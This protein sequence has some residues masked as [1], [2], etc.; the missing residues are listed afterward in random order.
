MISYELAW[1]YLISYSKYNHMRT[2]VS[3]PSTYSTR[4]H[5]KTSLLSARLRLPVFPAHSMRLVEFPRKCRFIRVSSS[6][7]KAI[8]ETTSLG[9]IVMR[10]SWEDAHIQAVGA[11]DIGW[12]WVTQVQQWSNSPSPTRKT[13]RGWFLRIAKRIPFGFWTWL[14]TC[15]DFEEPMTGGSAILGYQVEMV[16]D[17]ADWAPRI[18]AS[19]L[20][21][22]SASLELVRKPM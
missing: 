15:S 9:S 3:Y 19:I 4:R 16:W 17:W 21:T 18:A 14:P 5:W 11:E 6:R 13:S 2:N 8:P 20:A 7:S 12:Q 1:S 22:P 10:L